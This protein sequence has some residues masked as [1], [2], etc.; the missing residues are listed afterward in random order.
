M[1][2]PAYIRWAKVNNEFVPEIVQK[3][4]SS[5]RRQVKNARR[6]RSISLP[7]DEVIRIRHYKNR[8]MYCQNLSNY[9][10]YNEIIYFLENG[11]QVIFKDTSG[12]DITERVLK[13]ILKTVFDKSSFL[14]EELIDMIT[15]KIPMVLHSPAKQTLMR[16]CSQCK[17]LFISVQNNIG[18]N[19]A[20]CVSWN[21]K[22]KNL[23]TL[24]NANK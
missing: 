22:Y 18:E 3:I 13:Y 15:G 16:E 12:H 17:D 5:T 23:N 6:H 7:I 20:R 24:L 11:Y 4:I 14:K 19:C 9:V 21:Q 8:K 2:H 10:N 1:H